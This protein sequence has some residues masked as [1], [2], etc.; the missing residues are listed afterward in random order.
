MIYLLYGTDTVKARNKLHTVLN[1]LLAK[2]P[3]ATLLHIDNENFELSQ[4]DE[5]VHGQGLFEKRMVVVLDNIFQSS[6]AKEKVTD[7]LKEIADSDN[8]FIL[9]EEKV[10]S[11]LLRKLEKKSEKI[12]EF[13][14][15]GVL[16]KKRFDIFMLSDA[17]GRRDRKKLW[18]F[19]HKAKLSNISDEEIHGILFWQIKSMLIAGSSQDAKD[20]GLNP[21][22][23]KKSKSFLKNYSR[24]ELQKLSSS[25][26]S[27]YHDA[28]RGIHEL[29][30]GLELFLLK[31]I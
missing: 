28:R 20:A 6:E 29:D 24:E 25:L 8:I 1:S 4:L 7:N 19:Y 12:Q 2:R 10:D 5:L 31:S 13:E 3:E 15:K 23:F 30:V 17:L 11:A 9:L 14:M 22:V 21:Y 26:I 18:A 16:R 27:L